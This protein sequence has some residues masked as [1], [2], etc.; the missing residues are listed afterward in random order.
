MVLFSVLKVILQRLVPGAGRER[1]YSILLG[2]K[3][4]TEEQV[5][6]MVEELSLKHFNVPFLHKAYF[7]SRLKTTGGRYLLHSHNIELNKKLYDH[8]GEEELRGIILHELCHYHLHIR[9]MG[10]RHR[11]K[12]FRQLLEK[13]GAPRFCSSI[14]TEKKPRKQTIHMYNCASC[15][16]VYRRKRKMDVS[17]YRCGKCKG[18]IVYMKSEAFRER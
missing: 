7:N 9:G 18:E 15:H 8:F 5:Q 17:K 14:E 16:Q 4:M 10:Y 12:D 13:V 6:R 2:V 11:D 3:N 1:L